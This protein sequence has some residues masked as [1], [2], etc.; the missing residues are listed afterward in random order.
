MEANRF[1]RYF[2]EFH[3]GKTIWHETRKTIT[4]SDNNL[5]CLLTM[6]HHPAHLDAEYAKT[7]HHGKILVVGTLVLSLIVGIT[8]PDISGKAIANLGYEVDHTRP[9][10]IGDTL[11]AM[12]IIIGDK[13]LTK[14]KTRGIVQIRSQGH[15]QNNEVVIDIR[16]S[17]MVPVGPPESE[18]S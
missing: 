2:H 11:H 16:R 4:E 6:N 13:R 14:D 3:R 5:F 9:V 7:A 12:S 10:F 17:I 18:E 1:G 8:V 15:N